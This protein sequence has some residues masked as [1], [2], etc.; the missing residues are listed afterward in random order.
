MGPCTQC[1]YSLRDERICPE[2][3][4]SEPR[5]EARLRLERLRRS[6]IDWSSAG[7]CVGAPAWLGI[8]FVHGFFSSPWSVPAFLAAVVWCAAGVSIIVSRSALMRASIDTLKGLCVLAAAAGVLPY[9]I[10][11]LMWLS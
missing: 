10:V 1:G 3:G 4:L 2:C 5:S 6:I 11:A 8:W 7:P 9:A